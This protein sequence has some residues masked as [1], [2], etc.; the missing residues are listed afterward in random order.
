MRNP[1]AIFF[2]AWTLLH[3]KILTANNLIIRNQPN[4]PIC[5]LCGTDNETP[6]HLCKDCTFANEVWPILKRWLGLSAID[7]VGMSGWLHKHWRKCQAK[8]DRR[9]QKEFDGVMIYFWWNIWKERNR[10]T[11]QNKS[12]E[13]RQVPLLCN[14]DIQ[15]QRGVKFRC[16]VFPFRFPCLVVF[17]EASSWS[18]CFL[19]VS[20]EWVQGDAAV[21]TAPSLSG[22]CNYLFCFFF[23][24]SNKNPA[25][26]CCE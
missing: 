14:E 25:N 12:L 8:F 3:K 1:N 9:Q 26:L 24:S 2:F 10:I 20:L 21:V 19:L 5:K 4:D 16:L 23:Y 17:P 11:F 15:I 22:L 6:T 7:R 13:P 18:C